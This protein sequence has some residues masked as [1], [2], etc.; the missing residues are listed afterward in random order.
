MWIWLLHWGE[1]RIYDKEVRT[2]DWG[3]WERWPKHATPH[4]VAFVADPQII[5]PHTYPGRPWPLSSLTIA[6]TDKYL[7]RS[8]RLLQRRFDPDTTYFLGDLFDGGRE[9]STGETFHEV[10][11]RWHKYGKSYWDKEYKRFAKLFFDPSQVY[12]GEAGRRE[13]NI[14]ASLPGN[15]DLGFAAG[16]QGSVRRRFQAFF[17]K[18]DRVDVIGN[19]T[20]VGVDTVSLS[21]MDVADAAPE[22]WQS[23]NEFLD[24][25]K[26]ARL[27]AT[28]AL[29]GE[30]PEPPTGRKFVHSRVE[31][32]EQSISKA[33]HTSRDRKKLTEL[34]TVLLSHVPL[35]REPGTR[36]GFL[37]EKWPPSNFEQELDERNAIRVGG[38]YQY[39]NVLTKE[40]TKTI[41]EKVGNI[42]YAFSG[43]DHDYCELT[44][45]AYP[46]AGRGIHEITVKSLSFAMGVNHPGFVLA[47]LWNPIDE[48]AAPLP[49]TP[50]NLRS[51]TL[52][53]HLCLL[54][55]QLAILMQYGFY[56][57]ITIVLLLFSS[58]IATLEARNK[59]KDQQYNSILP[60][61]A[62]TPPYS[63]GNPSPTTAISGMS[64]ANGNGHLA[65]RSVNSRPKSV[66]PSNGVGGYGLP[67][68]GPKKKKMFI[69]AWAEQ[70]G[71]D[72]VWVGVPSLAWFLW[73]WNKY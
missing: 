31:P 64:G 41:A 27:Q 66:Q 61:K 70:L 24:G 18:G 56:V 10:D 73:L 4:H 50:G 6:F 5:D 38:G 62:P 20:F 68:S 29:L 23:T 22:I 43:D 11:K 65:P 55:N 19:H 60:M 42:D 8:Y 21:A 37:R 63:D 57:V 7:Q 1:V 9:W 30:L 44:H 58:V 15:H 59:P 33:Q 40:I 3:N 25:V 72:L 13:K 28:E 14:I 54:P 49:G 67:T 53:S 69:V 26:E 71:R 16:I 46:S 48:N 32:A 35:Y 52:H 17:G 34:P 39:Q 2:C 12:G 45:R 51:P 36:C 47:S